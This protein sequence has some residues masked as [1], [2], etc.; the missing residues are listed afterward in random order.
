MA[1]LS[2]CIPTSKATN[3]HSLKNIKEDIEV[4][5]AVNDP[6]IVVWSVFHSNHNYVSQERER[7]A[8]QSVRE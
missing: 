2:L 5:V 6:I 7:E 4:T 3:L 8:E 1:S